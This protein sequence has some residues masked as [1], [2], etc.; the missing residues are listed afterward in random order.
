MDN[1]EIE[2]AKRSI[3]YFTG[4]TYCEGEV[5]WDLLML[6]IEKLNDMGIK[7][8]IY[9]KFCKSTRKYFEDGVIAVHH[10]NSKIAALKCIYRTLVFHK[11]H[12][13]L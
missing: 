5:S 9:P 13:S 3:A 11:Q 12:L 2:K 1:E 4:L 10:G 8:I 7:V 6:S